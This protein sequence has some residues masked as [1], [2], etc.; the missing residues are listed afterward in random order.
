MKPPFFQDGQILIT[1]TSITWGSRVAN[2]PPNMVYPGFLN[3][4][5]TKDVS[6]SVTK[7]A[8]RHTFKSG[9]YSN[10]SMKD[11]NASSAVTFG[12]LNFSNDTSNPIDSQFGFAN[13]ALGVVSSYNQLSRY[14]EGHYVYYNLEGYVQDNWKVS[15]RLTLDYGVRLVHQQPQYDARLQT[16]NFFPE[17]FDSRAA[18][19]MF[20]AGCATGV[21]P[22]SGAAR[23][24]RNPVTGQLLG[25][26]S[27]AAIG[28]IVPGTGNLL[29]GLEVSGQGIPKTTYTYP[30][31][32]VAP[33]F[34]MA[35]DMTGNQKVVLRGGGGIF[36]D[37]PAGNDIY[38]QVTNP[39]AVQNV[40]VRYAQLQDLRSGLTT[41]G[42]PALNTYQF[43]AKVPA[44]FQWNGGAQWALPW[45]SVVDVSYA[46]QHTWGAPTGTGVLTGVN[47]NAIDFGTAFLPQFQDPTLAPSATPG[48]T[49]VATDLMRPMS[50]YGTISQRMS[51]GSRTFHSIQVS[52]QRR[53]R[54]G[55]SFGFHDTVSLS[56]KPE[57]RPARY[58]TIP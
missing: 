18:P 40:T 13:A 33:R 30:S 51:N 38:G 12:A 14:I 41:I 42:A 16:S 32:V 47:I 31:L 25:V 48:A 4:N 7:V 1:P 52:F 8:G 29:N 37:R 53:F 49:A 15:P 24:A 50:G 57:Q 3:I 10:H 26:G 22:C 56:D 35:Y 11:Q 28:T 46:G 6:I 34:G 36:F 21:S 54:N 2:A 27:A 17:K 45:S 58:S 39:P 19:A 5:A 44:S 23:Q 9:F 55:L 20:V 43:D